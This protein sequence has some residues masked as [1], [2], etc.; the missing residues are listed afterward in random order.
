L[1][2]ASIEIAENGVIEVEL[3]VGDKRRRLRWNESIVRAVY[4]GSNFREET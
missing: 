2:K 1:A 4:N 3:R